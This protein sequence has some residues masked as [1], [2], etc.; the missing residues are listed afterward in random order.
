MISLTPKT[1][2]L[3]L[4]DLQ[5][6]ILAMDTAPYPTVQVLETG[7]S[8]AGWFRAAGATV[9]LVN[10]DFGPDFGDAPRSLVDAP[11]PRG[12]ERPADW[13]EL[14]DDLL[15][16]G[17]LRVTKHQWGAFHG[18]DLDV[19]LR[20]RGIDTIV[21]GGIAT[22]FGVESTLRAGWEHG[23]NM[24]VVEDACTTVS[25][26]LHQMAMNRVFPRISRVVRAGELNFG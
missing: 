26:E 7:R 23:Y 18:T 12:D 14:A 19:K 15:E 21:L 20:R 4:I 22:N 10:V 16:P 1:T 5:N 13:S 8:L 24:V 3:V 25:E 2:A 9:V 17:D 11:M 6:G